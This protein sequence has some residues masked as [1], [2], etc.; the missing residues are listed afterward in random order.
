MCCSGQ[1]QLPTN[2]DLLN[3]WGSLSDMTH[4][5]QR[6]GDFGGDADALQVRASPVLL[7]SSPLRH[8]VIISGACQM[9]QAAYRC[10]TAALHGSIV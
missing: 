2:M 4:L 1:A 7:R 3:A 8:T 5:Q 10:E 9:L 6:A